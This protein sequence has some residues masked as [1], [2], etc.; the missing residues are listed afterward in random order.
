MRNPASL[1]DSNTNNLKMV[2]PSN[3]AMKYTIDMRHFIIM[4]FVSIS[5][6]FTL[7]AWTAWNDLSSYPLLNNTMDMNEHHINFQ[8]PSF[9][10]LG[11]GEGP[12]RYNQQRQSSSESPSIHKNAESHNDTHKRSQLPVGQHFLVDIKNVQASFLDCEKR[13]AQAMVD[14][15]QSVGLNLLSYHC[16]TLVPSGVSCV[17][18]ISGSHISFHTWPEEGVITLDL[19]TSN[20]DSPIMNVVSE[21]SRLFG[22][23]KEGEDGKNE[24]IITEWVHELRGFPYHGNNDYEFRPADKTNYL[25]SKSDLSTWVL[26]DSSLYSKEQIVSMTSEF[27]RID[28]WDVVLSDQKPSHWDALK[29]DLK[30][31]DPRW[32]TP[33]IASPRRILFVNGTIMVSFVCQN[34]IM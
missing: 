13:L 31:G 19:L 20:D 18:V 7:G 10:D 29:H 34:T 9:E 4:L 33:E 23:P 6:F 2:H 15:V 3:N 16:H 5:F 22:I 28:I 24:T 30:E 8:Q 14:A 32:M 17:G 12:I 27:N 26:S 1:K 25:H 21:L 11:H